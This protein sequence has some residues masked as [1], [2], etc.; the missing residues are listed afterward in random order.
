MNKIGFT[1]AGVLAITGV[2]TLLTTSIINQIMPK[3]GR[4]AFQ[5]AM[6]GS[7]SP[8]DYHINFLVINIIATCLIIMGSVL[9]FL[10]YKHELRTGS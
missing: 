4:A 5:C 9:G 10:V 3:I 1:F 7:Y 8:N 2:N 6:A